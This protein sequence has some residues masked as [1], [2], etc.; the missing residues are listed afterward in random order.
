MSAAC[1]PAHDLPANSMAHKDISPAGDVR[2]KPTVTDFSLTGHGQDGGQ[3]V[4]I[5]PRNLQ[6]FLPFK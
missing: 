2:R 1:G 5:S 6:N 3:P 4:S